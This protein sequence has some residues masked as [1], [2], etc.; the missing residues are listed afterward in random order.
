MKSLPVMLP[1][2]LQ[3]QVGLIDRSSGGGLFVWQ[4]GL[5][6]VVALIGSVATAQAQAVAA[7]ASVLS[8]L[9]KWT[10]LLAQGF[11]FNLAISFMAM[12]LG[13]AAG[14]VLGLA[15]VSL[16]APV[17]GV[18]NHGQHCRDCARCRAVDSL[19]AMGG[20]AFACL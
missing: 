15:R 10:P 7:Q 4:T 11:L 13:T 5:L 19:G 6:L 12:L 1:F 3:P 17:P 2:R 16:L 8:L 9:L 14:V 20:R 18:A